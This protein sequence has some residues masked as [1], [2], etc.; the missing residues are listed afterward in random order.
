MENRIQF[1]KYL[2]ERL[3][4]IELESENQLWAD[5]VH[6]KQVL[7]GNIYDAIGKKYLDYTGHGLKNVYDIL[8]K[9]YDLIE[10]DDK[11]FS[12]YELYLLGISILIHD[13]GMVY[14]RNGHERKISEIY[15]A[16]FGEYGDPHQKTIVLKIVKS[17]TGK[18]DDDSP[19]DT[20]ALV[21]KE[22]GFRSQKIKWCE[23]A[24]ILRFSDEISEG[25]FRTLPFLLFNDYY[26]DISEKHNRYA[27][28]LTIYCDS[29]GRR[30]VGV[31]AMDIQVFKQN[32]SLNWGS[33]KDYYSYVFKRISKLNGER[34]YNRAYSSILEPY[35]ATEYTIDISYEGKEIEHDIGTIKMVERVPGKHDEEVWES[36]EEKDSKPDDIDDFAEIVKKAIKKSKK[37]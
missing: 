36:W 35:R 16:I 30:I 37:K 21:P 34:K 12:P 13:V 11:Y 29:G 27:N 8:K 26:S 25:R 5:Y 9:A 10:Y 6:C 33:F 1:E 14:S 22:Y 19:I 7:I 32:G 17:H 31:H 2:Q 23:L 28:S 15:N 24:A 20:L 3:K 18:K 4:E